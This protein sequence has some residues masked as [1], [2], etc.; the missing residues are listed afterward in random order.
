MITGKAVADT[1]VNL[2]IPSI[3]RIP[4]V[5]AF[6]FIFN[7]TSVFFL[8]LVYE[9]FTVIVKLPVLIFAI[10]PVTA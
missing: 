1:K 2:Y 6:L 9:L 10:S 7:R 5:S 4:Q 8:L 3:Q